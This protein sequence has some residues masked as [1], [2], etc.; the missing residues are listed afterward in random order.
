M[1]VTFE[2]FGNEYNCDLL[3]VNCGTRDLLDP[4]SLRRFVHADGGLYA[5]DLTSGL[6]TNAFPGIFR[7]GGSGVSAWET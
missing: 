4:A 7:F 2:P 5:S 6:I 3:F 1:G